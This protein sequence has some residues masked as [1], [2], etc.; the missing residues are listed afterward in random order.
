MS[1]FTEVLLVSP[2]DDGKTWAL[3]RNF[4]Y[5]I[6]NE[7]SE[8]VIEV[9]IGFLTDFASVPF[10]LQWFIPKWGKYGNAAIIHD[11]LYWCQERP[12]AE[13]DSVFREA[14]GVMEVGP[15]KKSLIFW[16]V[17]IFGWW[18]WLRNQ[19]DS[20]S[21]FERVLSNVDIEAGARSLRRG[22]LQQVSRALVTQIKTATR[23]LGHESFSKLTSLVK[24]EDKGDG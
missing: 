18:A 2:L 9:P 19:Q 16:G 24:K 14:M 7:Q 20:E 23:S 17:R 15:F 5:A 13:A 21:G 1:R 22:S 3:M 4:G 11:W 6:G 10:F 12:R 8:D